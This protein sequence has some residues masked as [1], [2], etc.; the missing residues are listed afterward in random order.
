LLLSR[1]NVVEHF[2]AG[3][4]NRIWADY[5][6]WNNAALMNGTR[7]A[8]EQFSFGLEA[9]LLRKSS[10]ELRV[11]LF[12]QFGSKQPLGNTAASVELGNVSVFAKRV[13]LQGSC[14][15]VSGGVG[16]TLPTAE[17]WQPVNGV[18]LKNNAYYL[19]SFLGVQWHPNNR[20]FGH[21]IVQHD[22]PI[23]KNELLGTGKIDGQ[24]VIRTGV[25]LGRWIYRTD[26]GKQPCRFGVFAEVNYAVVTDG[27]PQYDSPNMD[28]YYVSAFDSRKSTLTAAAGMPMV[29]GKMTC[30][31]SLI[32]P[33]S[34]SNRPFSAGYNFSLS[35]TF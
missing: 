12:Y 19:V 15:T 14:L 26:H 20:S 21:F 9:Q 32:L 4:Q 16:T 23:E 24:Q 35:R 8:V 7:R 27:S 3:V 11:P 34:G 13:L 1:P 33:I 2:N 31:N 29:F 22:L 28:Y 30:T 25:Q 18:K 5:R 17:S 6:H 10:V